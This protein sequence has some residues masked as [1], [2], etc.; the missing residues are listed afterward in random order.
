MKTIGF[1]LY[2]SPALICSICKIE[3][4]T[5]DLFRSAKISSLPPISLF[6]SFFFPSSPHLSIFT[7]LPFYSLLLSSLVLSSLLFSSLLFSSLLFSSL[8][9]SSLLYSYTSI[10]LFCHF[11]PSLL[12]LHHLCPLPPILLLC[13]GSDFILISQSNICP[14]K[15]KDENEDESQQREGVKLKNMTERP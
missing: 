4:R 8:L 10:R 14:N 9:F 12:P 1:F 7:F 11:L 2:I 6:S 15:K 13:T 3:I 5:N